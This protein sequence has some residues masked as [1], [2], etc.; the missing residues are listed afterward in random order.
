[1]NDLKLYFAVYAVHED[2]AWRAYA[3]IVVAKST[4]DAMNFIADR[5]GEVKLKKLEKIELKEGMFLGWQD[6]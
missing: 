1:M 4:V 5:Y 2:R 3:T 6:P